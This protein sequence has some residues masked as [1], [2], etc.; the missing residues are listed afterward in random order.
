MIRLATQLFQK[1]GHIGGSRSTIN[2]CSIYSSHSNDAFLKFHFDGTV[3]QTRIWRFSRV[4]ISSMTFFSV[5]LSELWEIYN[6]RRKSPSGSSTDVQFQTSRRNLS[7]RWI[8]I[9]APVQ[10]QPTPSMVRLT[11]ISNAPLTISCDFLPLRFTINLCQFSCSNCDRRP[12]WGVRLVNV[13]Y[14]YNALT[15]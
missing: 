15:W 3:L 2:T 1:G 8:N 11:Q 13:L 10:S 4:K 12:A 7:G 6:L 9:P 5:L 14:R